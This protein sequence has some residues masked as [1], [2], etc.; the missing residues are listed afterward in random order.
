MEKFH[1]FQTDPS[2]K[3][4]DRVQQAL[5]YYQY[6][7]RTKQ[8]YCRWIKEYIRFLG[9]R[10]VPQDRFQKE[11]GSFLEFLIQERK[12]SSASKKQAL[13]AIVFLYKRVFDVGI[14]VKIEPVKTRRKII[15]PMVL[16]KQEVKRVLSGLKGK[17]LLMAQLLYGSGLRLMECIRLKVHDLDF[18]QER[19]S[20]TPVKGGNKRTVMMPK[21]VWQELFDQVETIRKIHDKDLEM[22]YGQD[23]LPDTQNQSENGVEKKFS[24]QYVFPSKKRIAN[25]VTGM[26]HRPHVPE[27]GLQKAVKTAVKRAGIEK[28]VS[29]NTFRHS[30]AV[31]LLENNVNIHSVKDLMGH[32]DIKAT[33]VYTHVMEKREAPVLSPLDLL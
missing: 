15:L 9:L 22:E 27:S 29:C 14:D 12:L 23:D 13:H 7:Y 11:I 26:A 6:S 32:V 3:L 18:K 20:V 4:M 1:K 24:C 5:L 17:H 21:L 25:P 31:H 19:I 10:K 2:L 30:F 33:Q 8:S 16:T 28:P